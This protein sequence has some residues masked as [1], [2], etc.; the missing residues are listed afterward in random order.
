MGESFSSTTPVGFINK[1]EAYRVG[2]QV[3]AR[4]LKGVGGWAGDPIRYL[5]YHC[6]ELYMKAALISA[7]RT[8]SQLRVLSHSFVKLAEA[9]NAAGL[10]LSEQDDLNVLALIDSQNNYIKA[11]YHY[12]GGFKVATV[13]ALDCT[14]HE[15]AVL[16]VQMIR[17]SGVPVREPRPA[18]P[19]E[20]RF[21]I[22]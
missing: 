21:L 7:G 14:A 9:C 17:R 12:V 3:L 5:Y 18:L 6:I 15:L 2:A 1:A 20:N 13:Q 19:F 16:A 8:G 22:G 4:E 11:R 10:G